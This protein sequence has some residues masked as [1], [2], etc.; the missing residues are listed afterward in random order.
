MVPESDAFN[1]VDAQ[2]AAW[3]DGSTQLESL[4]TGDWSVHEWLYFLNNLPENLSIDQLS[5]LDRVFGLTESRNNEIVHSWL[6]HVIRHDYRPGFARLES[7]LIGIG[8]RKLI[9]PLYEDL[10]KTDAHRTFAE[11]VYARARPG[12]HPLAQA[13]VDRI[14]N[15]GN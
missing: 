2:S 11:E 6:R 8:R 5:E 10:N 9:T 13:T 4:E 1:A 14:L 3:L 7:Y 15:G 12:Y